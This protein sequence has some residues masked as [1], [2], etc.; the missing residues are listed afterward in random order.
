MK[1]R[2]EVFKYNPFAGVDHEEVAQILV[3]RF[4]TE[5]ILNKII[6]S[7]ELLIELIGRQG[8]GKTTHLTFLHQKLKEIPIYYLHAGENNY[9]EI[10]SDKSETVFIDSIHHLNIYQR[11]QVFKAKKTIIFT[12]HFTRKF[13][14]LVVKKPIFQ[15][16][17]KGIDKALLRKLVTKRLQFISSELTEELIISDLELE[18]LIA[19]Y[20]DNYRGI[21]NHLYDKFQD[22]G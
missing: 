5:D 7:D 18:Q 14:G 3:P 19:Q 1:M 9:Q 2:K 4:D 16:R 13:E 11:L 17:F 6:S 15:I 8:R 21:V 22:Y 12:T 10:L 20:G